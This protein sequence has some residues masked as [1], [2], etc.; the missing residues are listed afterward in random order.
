MV[1]GVEQREA[2]VSPQIKLADFCEFV[3]R[4]LSSTT[5]TI[6]WNF[7]REI[8]YFIIIFTLAGGV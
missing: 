7:I 1:H 3:C 2:T 5:P 8:W 4:L 6:V